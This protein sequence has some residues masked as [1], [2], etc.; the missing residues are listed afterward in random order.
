[1]VFVGEIASSGT[2]K[3]AG[4]RDH[5]RWHEITVYKTIDN[6]VVVI[7]RYRT[8]WQG[9]MEHSQAERFKTNAEAARFL[10]AYSWPNMGSIGWPPL[11]DYERKQE[12]LMADLKLGWS[13][14]VGEVLHEL[15]GAEEAV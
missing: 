1:M 8:Q 3:Q 13:N 6:D 9:E 14:L 11:P 5:N 4:G 7:V 10:E 2:S 12:R 15:P